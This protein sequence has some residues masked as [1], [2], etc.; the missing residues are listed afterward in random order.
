MV[1][2]LDICNYTKLSPLFYMKNIKSN[3]V[4]GDFVFV[5]LLRHKID[6]L[7]IKDKFLWFKC[8]PKLI[9]KEQQ[10]LTLSEFKRLLVHNKKVEEEFIDKYIDWENRNESL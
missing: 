1:N 4:T 7:S 2:L 5:D 10:F 3:E 9:K 8:K 6:V